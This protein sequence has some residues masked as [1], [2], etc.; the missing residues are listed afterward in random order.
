M[1]LR[2]E[3]SAGIKASNTK[4]RITVLLGC[5]AVGNNLKPLAIG[6]SARPRCFQ[7]ANMAE[8]D[9]HANK[10]AWMTS[11]IFEEWVRKLNNKMVI[12]CRHILLVL[13]NRTAQPHIELSNIKLLTL[14]PNTTSALQPMDAGIIA[15]VKMNYS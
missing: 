7:G 6:K 14:P 9:Y 2:G 8:K 1:V 10:N 5:N 13:D 15:A 4:E 12:Q 11:N 3:D